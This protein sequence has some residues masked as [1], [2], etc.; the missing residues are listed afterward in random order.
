MFKIRHMDCGAV[1]DRNFQLN[2][3]SGFDCYLALFVKSRAFFTIDGNEIITEPDMFIVY[4]KGSPIKYRT[5]GDKY[6]NDWIQF[7]SDSRPNVDFSTPVY[8]E[9]NIHVSGYMRMIC[10]AFYRRSEQACSYLMY[11]MFSEISQFTGRQNQRISH[12]RE[13]TDMRR[14]MY[15]KPEL[16]WSVNSMAEHIHVSA[17]YLQELYRNAFGITCGA[18]LICSRIAAA[19]D[20]LDGTEMSVEEVG[21]KCG[22]NNPV[23]FSR[24]FSQITGMPPSKW[25]KR[26]I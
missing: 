19:K 23:H 12:F 26:K 13:L 15:M 24:Q 11:A 25:K 2:R 6:I 17:A 5:Y 1:H 7:E 16:D 18:D 20:L 14:E 10:D 3:Q 21:Y 4:D 8:A 9:E 22:Y